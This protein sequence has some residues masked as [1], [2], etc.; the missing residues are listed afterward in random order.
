MDISDLGIIEIEEIPPSLE[1]TATQVEALADELIAYHAEFADLY[2]RSEQAHWG[3]KYLQGLIAPIESKAIQ[4]MALDLDG[5]DVRAMQQF[6]GQG[7]WE[8]EKLLRKHWKLVDETLGEEDGVWIVDGSG[9]PK[10]GEHSVGV[11]RQWCGQLGKVANCQVG[12][13]AAYASRKG[14]TLLDQRL[15]LP[16]QWFDQDHQERWKKCG[17]PE[18]TTFETKPELALEMFRA[19][20]EDATLRF[21]WVTCD[22]AYGKSPAF[23]DGIA[24]LNRWYF[25]EVPHNIRAWE[26]RPKTATPEWCGRGPKPTRKRVVEGEPRSK[27]VDEIAAAVPKD[28]WRSRLIKEGSK[29]P[30]VAEFAFSR[31]IE[32]RNELP[33]DEV[34]LVLRRSLGE[35]PELKT[36]L[37]NAPA[38]INHAR[39]ARVAGMR[40]PVETALEDGKDNLGMDEYMV[41]SWT[42]WHH[43]MTESVLAHHFLVRV[44]KKLER[45][46]PALT[47]QQA[48][49]LIASVLPLKQLT[50]QEA[51]RRVRFIQKQN[52]AAYLSHR[53]RTIQRLNGL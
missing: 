38:D 22:E 19:V 46:A 16:K 7:K 32:V 52:H 43:H 6:I 29:G 9:F 50:P 8:D 51:I 40:W 27:R 20:V 34:W 4:P 42:G 23:L 31:V 26:T 28:D 14:Y 35:N 24:E 13:F 1:L 48:R 37:C 3:F 30:M 17:V 36:Y 47:L 21:Q 49:R 18:G 39:L 12:V 2:Y 25:A 5:G 11:A 45:E 10:K 44:Q 15:Y 53:K 41:R 33:G